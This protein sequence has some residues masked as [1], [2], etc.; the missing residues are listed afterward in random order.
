MLTTERHGQV[1]VATMDDGKANALSH[2]L[3]DALRA[4]VAEAE[5]DDDVRALVLVGRA[6]RFCAGFDLSV[7]NEGPAAQARLVAAGGDL[8]RTM[9]A[10][11]VPV[12]AACTGHAL[13]AGA[14]LLLGCDRR[15]G[16]DAPVKIGLNEV[17]IG[18]A[19]P[20][21][22][23]ALAAARLAPTHLQAS[24]ATGQLYDGAGAV[25]AGY[26]DRIVPPETVVAEA[27]AEA[28]SLVTVDP[29]A[30]ASVIRSLRSTTLEQMAP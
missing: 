19:L 27:I 29:T 21:W 23:I 5:T 11:G 25:A 17:A 3:I 15:V 12:V 4:V 9:Y 28:Q 14:L 30:Y 10:V 16:V 1:L 26:L 24:A 2:A 20:G 18:L 6:G 7:M 13:A 22:A 8:I